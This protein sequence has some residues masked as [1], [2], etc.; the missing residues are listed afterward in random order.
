MSYSNPKQCIR[1]PVALTTRPLTS[2]TLTDPSLSTEIL[3][4]RHESAGLFSSG[5]HAYLSALVP[6]LSI[7]QQHKCAMKTYLKRSSHLRIQLRHK[8]D[9]VEQLRREF[10]DKKLQH[11]AAAKRDH[12]KILSVN[13]VTDQLPA[14]RSY[15]LQEIDKVPED[16]Y[17][18]GVTSPNEVYVY[19][20]YTRNLTADQICY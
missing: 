20:P 8:S 15:R 18:F 9:I 19:F 2:Y 11:L 1:L 13:G 7:F 14:Q 3:F 6:M 5:R 10:N 12:A 16:I 17:G 4:A